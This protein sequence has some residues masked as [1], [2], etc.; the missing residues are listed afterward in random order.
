MIQLAQ[1]TL[2][3]TAWLLVQTAMAPE[4]YENERGFRFG[5]ER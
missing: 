5:R 1:I 4:G 3:L 2:V